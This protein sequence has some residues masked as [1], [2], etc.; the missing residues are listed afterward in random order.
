MVRLYPAYATT[1][2]PIYRKVE[3]E[4]GLIPAFSFYFR[5]QQHT[6]LFGFLSIQQVFQIL[7]SLPEI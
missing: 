6:L 4:G 5:L 3:G 1:G 2:I 7:R